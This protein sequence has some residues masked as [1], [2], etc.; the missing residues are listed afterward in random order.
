MSEELQAALIEKYAFAPGEIPAGSYSG[1]VKEPVRTVAVNTTLAVHKDVPEEIVYRITKIIAENA[2]RVR[3]THDSAQVF[4]PA[5][6]W[7][8]VGAPLHPGAERYYRE[9]GYLTD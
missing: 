9:A 2:D 4:D 6:A 7:Q 5:T 1:M 8:H 3:A